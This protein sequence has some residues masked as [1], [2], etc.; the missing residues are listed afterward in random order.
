M[1]TQ[2]DCFSCI[3]RQALSAARFAQCDEAT[4]RKVMNR[5]LGALQELPEESTPPQTATLIHHLIRDAIGNPDPYREVKARSTREALELYPTLKGMVAESDA[6]FVTA[7]KLAIAGNIIDLSV[8]DRYD[9]VGNVQKVL[10]QPLT[11]D[12]TGLLSQLIQASPWVLYLA[13]NAG[14]TVFDRVLI[15]QIQPKRVVYVVKGGPIINDATYSDAVAAGLD[16][17]AEI[18][19]TGYDTVGVMLNKINEQTQQL[20]ESAPVIIAKGMGNYE[21]LSDCA[22]YPLFFL[23]QVKCDAISLDVGTPTGSL[24]ARHGLYPA[25]NG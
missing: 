10:S 19:S 13:D 14:E 7:V 8:S 2:L 22:D 9:L 6:P 17:V 18:V 15:E 16:Q 4:Q 3:V 5:V 24:I 11:I 25:W 21:T 1:K 23:L 20:F 12:D